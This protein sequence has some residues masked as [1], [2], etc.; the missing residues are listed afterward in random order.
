MAE[1]DEAVEA[2]E[3]TGE[4]SLSE[5]FED[6]PEAKAEEES[7]GEDIDKPEDV[8]APELD[9]EEE[10]K[11]ESEEEEKPETEEEPKAETPT[12]EQGQLAALLA[13]R[14]KRQEVER[15]LEELEG[16]EE[17][18]EEEQA[19][20]TTL[21][22]NERKLRIELSRDFMIETDPEY[23]KT[24][25]P[26]FM[27]QVLTEA[28]EIKDE[29]LLQ[30]FYAA[31]SP[32]KYVRDYAK[33]QIEVERLS[34]PKY[35]ER[36]KADARKEVLAEIEAESKKLADAKV[37]N[38]AQATEDGSNSTP[39]EEPEQFQNIFKDSPL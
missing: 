2:A 37:P 29:K 21:Q 8:K 1:S 22:T 31:P 25:E 34:D 10:S 26:Y 28:G 20:H 19:L 35:I 32:A 12:A 9:V 38:L 13:E 23:E 18:S 39:V 36:I 16:K 3:S 5:L 6:E 15:R 7:K 30:E 27:R 33:K 14:Q 4:Q 24:Y 17:P 11:G